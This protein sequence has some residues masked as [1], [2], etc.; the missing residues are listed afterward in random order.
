MRRQQ[1]WALI[2]A[3]GLLAACGN[4]GAGSTASG[5]PSPTTA[6]PESASP[7]LAV[8]TPATTDTPMPTATATPTTSATMAPAVSATTAPVGAGCEADLG[9]AA[10]DLPNGREVTNQATGDLDGDGE[11]DQLSTFKVSLGEDE[12]I[13]MLHVVAATGFAAEV[14]LGEADAMANVRPLGTVP[15]GDGLHA[16]LVVEGV[17]A[18]NE[19]VSL[20]GL[21]DW[22]DD[23]CALGRLTVADDM[24]PLTYPVGGTAGEAHGLRCVEADGAPALAVTTTTPTNDDQTDW[25]SQV[26]A[27]SGAGALNLVGSDQGQVSTSEAAAYTGINCPDISLE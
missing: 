20:W 2:I 4:T 23:P 25:S 16:A 12:A 3:A 26:I 19:L 21:H 5:E 8:T 13:W 11:D 15:I 17:G 6:A 27:W 22:D 24:S 14:E 18:S 7:D 10:T 1:G 9:T